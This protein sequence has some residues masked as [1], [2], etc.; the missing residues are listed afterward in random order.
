VPEKNTQTVEFITCGRLDFGSFL[1]GQNTYG[2]IRGG[3]QSMVFGFL[4]AGVINV[5]PG[6]FPISKVADNDNELE[7]CHSITKPGDKVLLHWKDLSPYRS[8]RRPFQCH[9]GHPDMATATACPGVE[10]RLHFQ[11]RV[12]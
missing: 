5:F 4:Q 8:S 9:Q 11:L 6:V 1:V 3:H 10:Q 7:T 2:Q 12:L